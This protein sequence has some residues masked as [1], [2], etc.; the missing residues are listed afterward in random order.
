MAKFYNK[1]EIRKIG[2]LVRRLREDNE[3]SIE[4]I[5]SMTGFARSTITAIEKGS[6]TDLI[7]LIEI[8]KAIGVHPMELLNISLEIRPR[9]KLS[10]KRLARNPLTLR[11]NKMILETQFFYKPRFVSDVID[12][13]QQEFQ[14]KANS[15]HISV[16][17]KRMGK[18]GK[19]KYDK[20]GRQN[21]YFMAKWNE[22]KKL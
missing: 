5:A 21:S 8:A 2:D 14:I 6:N 19:L 17:L 9:Y 18:D 20:I 10:P 12:Y 4:D 13:L 1:K 16:V 11:I 15:T 7:H 3:W 22:P